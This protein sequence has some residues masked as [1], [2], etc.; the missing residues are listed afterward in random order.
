MTEASP[1]DQGT[2]E[3]GTSLH[4]GAW[5]LC[6]S[7]RGSWGCWRDTSLSCRGSP[8][9]SPEASAGTRLPCGGAGQGGGGGD[10]APDS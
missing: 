4:V 9:R 7:R 2:E 6:R 5:L 10:K 1:K 8:G 3:G